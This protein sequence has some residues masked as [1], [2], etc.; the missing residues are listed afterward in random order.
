MEKLLNMKTLEVDTLINADKEI[1]LSN[2]DWEYYKRAF[3]SE[4]S[5]KPTTKKG[6]LLVLIASYKHLYGP[7]IILTIKGQV[8][9]K[10]IRGNG[11]QKN[12]LKLIN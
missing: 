9:K 5:S 8:I 2:S 3:K 6:L 11:N 12:F 10:K 7:D 4:K 1:D